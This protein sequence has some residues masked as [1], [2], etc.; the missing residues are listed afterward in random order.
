MKRF[1]RDRMSWAFI[2]F[3]LAGA[4]FVPTAGS[5]TQP[6][7]RASVSSIGPALAKSM[8]SWHRG[9]PV[10]VSDLRLVKVSF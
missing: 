10:P 5:Q 7:F 2:A 3:M 1:G 4:L 9:C 6:P 8:T